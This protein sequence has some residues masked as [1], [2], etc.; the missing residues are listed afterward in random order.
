MLELREIALNFIKNQNA[1]D[2]NA[3]IQFARWDK[4]LKLAPCDK[5]KISAFF[6]GVQQRL[7]NVS[8]G[9]RCNDIKSWTIYLRVHISIQQSIVL[10]KRFI[11]RGTVITRADLVVDNIQVSNPNTHYFQDPREV[12]GKVAK[13]SISIGKKISATSLKAA[14]IIKRG[15]EVTIIASTAGIIIRTKGKALSD[16]AK[17]QVVKVKNSRSK[18]ELQATVIAP[19]IVKVNM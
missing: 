18:R 7:G 15:Q 9:L 19:N 1:A 12:I 3:R 11:N 16:G 2:A 17:G 10:S 4:R 14:M 8:V 13:R 6:P 5:N